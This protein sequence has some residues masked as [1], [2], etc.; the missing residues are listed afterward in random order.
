MRVNNK[1]QFGIA[2][3]TYPIPRIVLAVQS[4]CHLARAIT[5]LPFEATHGMYSPHSCTVFM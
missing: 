3:F 2:I 4:F 1:Q 5:S